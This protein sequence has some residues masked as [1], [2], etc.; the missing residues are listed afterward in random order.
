LITES[1]YQEK[2][3]LKRNNLT[4]SHSK[5]R[6]F[7]TR[8]FPQRVE[9]ELHHWE[10]IKIIPIVL[11][12]PYTKHRGKKRRSH[13]SRKG[14]IADDMIGRGNAEEGKK[15]VPTRSKCFPSLKI[16]KERSRLGKAHTI[17]GVG[18][19]RSLNRKI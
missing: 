11:S 19:G 15:G 10:H 13:Q 17:G 9:E 16:V 4:T 8:D 18:R 6:F 14:S 3:P 5:Y 1:L 2:K 7:A 12:P